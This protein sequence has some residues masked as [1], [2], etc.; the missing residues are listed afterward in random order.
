M[1]ENKGGKYKY[2]CKLKATKI[3]KKYKNTIKNL[4]SS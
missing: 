1:A 2:S 3:T 4:A